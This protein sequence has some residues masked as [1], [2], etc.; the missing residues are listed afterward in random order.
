MNFMKQRLIPQESTGKPELSFYSHLPRNNALTLAHLF[1]I[2]KEK[3]S[4]EVM[5]ADWDILRRLL[6]AYEAGRD[7][8]L[9]S[10]LRHELLPVPLALAEMNG[11]LRRGEKAPLLKLL[12]ASNECPSTLHIIRDMSH[13]II[14][15]QAIVV[16]L[17]K[18]AYLKHVL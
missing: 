3:N 12:T 11:N 13:L 18:P 2:P 1:Q 14:D 15:G 8:D 5:K 9:Q 16:A 7:V 4:K 10:I 6:V 17:G